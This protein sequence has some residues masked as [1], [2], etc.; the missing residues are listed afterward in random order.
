M[1]SW[2][3]ER[4]NLVREHVEVAHIASILVFALTLASLFRVTYGPETMFWWTAMIAAVILLG[5]ALGYLSKSMV[6]SDGSRHS[7]RLVGY[8]L[9]GFLLA[10]ATGI[11]VVTGGQESSVKVIYVIPVILAAVN[12]GKRTGLIFAG[13]ASLALL[14]VCL[15]TGEGEFSNKVLEAGLVHTGV[16][17]LSS[18]LIGGLADIEKGVRQYLARLASED[19]I[20]GL[21]NHRHFHER[22]DYLLQQAEKDR[23][24][25]SVILLD[26]DFF[27]FYN[28]TYGHQR[29]DEV[30]KETGELLR[31]YVSP[32][33]F[34]ARYGGDEFAGVLP[35]VDSHEAAALGETLRQVIQHHD[36]YGKEIQPQGKLTV[37]VGVATY[38][39]HAASKKELIKCVFDT[40]GKVKFTSKNRVEVYF[41]VFDELKNVMAESERDLLNSVRTLISVVNAKDRYTYGHSERVVRYAR[42]LARKV[43]MPEKEISLLGYG[44]FLHDIGKIE[45]P[46]EVLNKLGPLAREEWLVLQQHPVW[47]A[48]MVRPARSI[49]G[50]IPVI[51]YHHENYDGSGY[52]EGLSGEQIPLGARI[53]RIV[54]S[55]DAM[56]TNRPYKRPKTKTEA[57]AELRRGSGRFYDPEL[58]EEFIE[59]VQETKRSEILA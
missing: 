20:T 25:L 41:S 36:F 56:V 14:A 49:A 59:L 50:V 54:D 16:F 19:D 44:A 27:K 13:V 22:L 4:V 57:L 28:D 7:Y 53:L 40:L 39:E 18:W 35:G 24:P 58:V 5:L 31:A 12:Y 52:P 21:V 6:P 33:G 2:E 34:I 9:L 29:G 47:G 26:L 55:F 32:P 51:L 1:N 15:A 37:S 42:Q 43:G 11:V 46:R 30:L 23:Q 45:V 8:L 3:R 38:P 10:V 17:F 48:D